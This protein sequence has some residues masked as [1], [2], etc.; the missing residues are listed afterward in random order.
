MLLKHA[1]SWDDAQNWKSY[2]SSNAKPFSVIR[3]GPSLVYHHLLALRLSPRIHYGLNPF[4]SLRTTSQ[5][6]KQSVTELAHCCELLTISGNTS[7]LK[8]LPC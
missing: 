3:H 2:Q 6:K 5:Q 1:F 7:C 8:V 4:V